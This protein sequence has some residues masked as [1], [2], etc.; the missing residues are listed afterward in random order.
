V[1]GWGPPPSAPVPG[2]EPIVGWVVP[3]EPPGLGVGAIIRAGW[4]LTT[5]HLVP[6]AAIAAIP[7]VVINLLALP[8]WWSLGETYQK[9]FDF[10]ANLD[11]QRYVDDPE[12]VS[13]EMNA[14]F[15]QSPQMSLLVAVAGGLSVIIGMIGWAALTQATLD[16]IDGRRPTI[17]SAYRAVGQ[18]SRQV[19]LVGA[20]LAIGYVAVLAPIS[21]NQSAVAYGGY[22]TARNTLAALLGIVLIAVE[23]A[24][25]YLTVR[26]AVY[27][28]VVMAEDLSI[29]AALARSTSITQGVRVK[30]FLVFLSLTLVVGLVLGLL[31]VVAAV[32]V[33]IAAESFAA[34]V[35]TWVVVIAVASLIVFP[36]TVAALTHVYRVRAASEAAAD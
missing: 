8:L 25:V 9:L 11:W 5:A 7:L 1:S 12:G 36:L 20:V 30:V 35:L 22:G 4:R 23:I 21:L 15:A 19:I 29:R 3:N 18:R 33:G 28:Q 31:G 32:I 26:W 14:I 27:F 2:P 17:A 10:Y 34:A 24:V 13:Q 16:A 6:F